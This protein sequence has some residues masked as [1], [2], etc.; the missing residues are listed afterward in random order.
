MRIDYGTG[1]ELNFI[2]FLL[3]LFKLEFFD[4]TDY[5]S[6][7][8]KVFYKYLFLMRKL[9]EDYKLEPAG[10]HGVWGLDDYHFLPFLFGASELKGHD[11][12]DGLAPY[13]RPI[14]VHDL[15]ILST[16]AEEYLYLGCIQ[17]IMKAKA[18]A[19]FGEHSPTL[20][21][22][23]AVNSWEKIAK[24]MVKMY[25]A[26]VLSKMP[27]MKHFFFGSILKLE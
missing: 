24:G 16:F 17:W 26:E 10:S 12:E 25:Q 20:N 11:V 21:D 3:C 18:K 9:Q 1:H 6:I 22:I 15:S 23:S 19:P 5:R 14:D 2:C 8:H 4:T 7:V 13:V 27:V